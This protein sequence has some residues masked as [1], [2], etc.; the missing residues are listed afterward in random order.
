[1]RAHNAQDKVPPRMPSH[2]T[3]T[4]SLGV[5]YT[6]REGLTLTAT[7][8][9]I[10][11]GTYPNSNLTILSKQ[12]PWLVPVCYLGNGTWHYC[13]V[14]FDMHTSTIELTDNNKVKLC[15]SLPEAP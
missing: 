13:G 6:L 8:V 11:P 10:L 14:Y 2:S 12:K 1:M 7:L 9:G 5:Y 15:F 3:G 4:L